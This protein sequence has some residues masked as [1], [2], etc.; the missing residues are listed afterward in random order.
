MKAALRKKYKNLRAALSADTLHGLSS[1]IINKLID[2]FELEGKSISI[3]LPIKRFNEIN[4]WLLIDQVKANFYL[5]VMQNDALVHLLF[6]SKAQLKTNNWGIEEP[7]YGQQTLP[8]T[9]DIV[10]VPLLAFD[11]HGTR[12]GYG[13]GF[14]DGFLKN[15]QENCK[16]IGV[17][18]FE[19]EPEVIP[20]FETDIP[21]DFCVTP[22]KI[23]TF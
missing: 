17:S 7:Q 6:E 8:K 13:K 19:A 9:F 2:E 11:K 22:K 15:C 16:F 5:P 23:Y 12:V 14:Y 4:T 20:P 10:I 1:T 18:F 3:F 21:L